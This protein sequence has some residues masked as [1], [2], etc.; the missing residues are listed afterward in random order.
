MRIN[1]QFYRTV[2]FLLGIFFVLSQVVMMFSINLKNYQQTDNFSGSYFFIILASI[3]LI[4]SVIF[5][6][7][8]LETDD[9]R[10]QKRHILEMTAI[11]FTAEIILV[12]LLVS[13]LIN[14]KMMFGLMF[15]IAAIALSFDGKYGGQVSSE[16]S[17]SARILSII[18]IVVLVILLL[19]PVLIALFMK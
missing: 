18:L 19:I 17:R 5:T 10:I 1:R 7:Q 12:I 2:D 4:K 9:N 11:L 13:G 8:P 14:S 15:V 3:C 16:P 6:N